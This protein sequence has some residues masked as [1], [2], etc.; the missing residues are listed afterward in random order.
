MFAQIH[1]ARLLAALT[2]IAA[3]AA[4]ATAIGAQTAQSATRCSLSA[5]ERYPKVTKPTYNLTVKVTATSCAT[6]KRV[7]KSY[8]AC[9]SVTGVRCT[10]KVRRSWTCTGK[11]TSTIPTQFEG[12][13]TCKYGS[14][15]V[16]STFQQ[17]V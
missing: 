9:R 3:L 5:S 4:L 7:I 15:R 8:H 2:L 6:G 1:P 11:K 14:R 12:S 16:T 13:V 17:N 10:K